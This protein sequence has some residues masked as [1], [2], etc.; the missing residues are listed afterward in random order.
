MLLQ[1]DCEI[2]VSKKLSNDQE[3]IQSDPTLYLSRVHV[4]NLHTGAE[5]HPGCK[6]AT[7][8]NLWPGEWCF[9]KIHPGANLRQGADLLPGAN[10]AHERTIL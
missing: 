7:R 6:F 4:N 5:I 10:R 9:K 1:H 2:M 8:M 3:L